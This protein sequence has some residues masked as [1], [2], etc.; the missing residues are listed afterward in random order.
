MEDK[1]RTL[2]F[3]DFAWCVGDIADSD[4][5]EETASV[6]GYRV[7]VVLDSEKGD[8][9][10]TNAEDN[11]ASV[12]FQTQA[13]TTA[14]QAML[15]P[16]FGPPRR[17]IHLYFRDEEMTD[18]TKA[19]FEALGIE[20]IPST[21]VIKNQAASPEDPVRKC[22]SCMLQRPRSQLKKCTGCKAMLY[23]SKECQICDWKSLHGDYLSHKLWCKKIADF[24]KKTDELKNLPFTY[25]SET[26]SKNFSRY[27]Y[28]EF[29]QKMGV[30]E[31]GMWNVEFLASKYDYPTYGNLQ[32]GDN[33]YVL[34]VESSILEEQPTDNA[35]RISP[36]TDWKIYY[37]WRGF[38]LD[39]PI[40]ILLQYP[41]TLYYILTT[42][43][44]KDYPSAKQI[45]AAQLTIHVVGAEKEASIIPVF[46]ELGALLPEIQLTIILIGP[47]I[48][49]KVHKKQ[50]QHQN[51]NVTIHK[52]LYEKYPGVR[53][54]LIIGSTVP[55]KSNQSEHMVSDDMA[56]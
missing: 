7:L 1:I 19:K 10:T 50:M 26:S 43:L 12:S 48:C 38:R 34:P 18:E 5:E 25:M 16:V 13:Y 55:H 52:G 17:P 9:V 41:L 37:D 51:V 11:L 15:N 20:W 42:C 29:L 31:Q 36:L 4:E 27:R 6:R 56:P 14:C 44:P 46:W 2:P 30:L 23:C 21:K 32:Y 53:P 3:T 39:S 49:K 22:A 45:D 8:L 54:D 47:E 40:A 33:P 35:Q 28:K 24:M